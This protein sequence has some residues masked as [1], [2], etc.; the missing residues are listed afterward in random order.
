MRA[1]RPV[2]LRLGRVYTRLEAPVGPFGL[3]TLAASTRALASRSPDRYAATERLL[4]RL[5][6]SRD[7]IAGRM[8]GLLLGAAFA[9]RPVNV[10]VASRLIRQSEALL[11]QARALAHRQSPASTPR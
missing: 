7:A 8:R 11:A 1:H 9:G 6:R 2:L 3:A 4:T 10:P 5:G